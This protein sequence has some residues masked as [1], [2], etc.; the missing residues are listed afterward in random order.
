MRST[1]Y[2]AKDESASGA[3]LLL[4]LLLALPAL[5]DEA[6]EFTGKVAK[7]S[8]GDTIT[9]LRDDGEREKIRLAGIDCPEKGQPFGEQAKEFTEEFCLGKEVKIAVEGSPR[10]SHAKTG[11]DRYGRVLGEAILP[12]GRVLNEELLREG[13]AWWYRRYAPDNATYEKLE[14]EAR[15]AGRGLWPVPPWEFRKRRAN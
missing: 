10:R 9:V 7:V 4:A 13:L 12:D 6:Q 8:D 15:E 3:C 2:H 5:A 11:K 1:F 14:R